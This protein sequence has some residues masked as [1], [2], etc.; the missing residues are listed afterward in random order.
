MR[1]PEQ[2]ARAA[3]DDL[4]RAAGWQVCGVTDANIHGASGV[5]I[6]EFPLPRYGLA[7]T[8]SCTWTARP[9]GRGEKIRGDP[10]R[11]RN[12]IGQVHRW[13]A[14]VAAGLV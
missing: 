7:A 3:I 6:R 5:A 2:I 1:E 13:A 11:G 14:R 9:L 12:P 4:L 10:L 8:T